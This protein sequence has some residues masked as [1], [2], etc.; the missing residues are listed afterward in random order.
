[1]DA[2]EA[3]RRLAEA[4]GIEARYWDIHGQLHEAAPDT[5]RAL[6]RALGFAADTEA[7]VEAGLAW[8]AEEPWRSPLPSVII[9]RENSEIDVPFRLPADD[10]AKTIRWTVRLETGGIRTGE[11]ELGA[12]Q[13]EGMGRRGETSALLRRFKLAPLPLGYHDLHLAAASEATARLIVAPSRCYLPP[14]FSSLKCWGLAAQLYALK[15]PDDWGIGDFGHLQTLIDRLAAGDADTVG[16]NPLHALF[17]DVPEYVSPYAP[18]SRLFRNSLY[19]DVTAIPDFAE[20]DEARALVESSD[21]ALLLRR[22]RDA[23]F[24]DYKTVAAVK[25]AVLDCLYSSFTANHVARMDGRGAAFRAFTERSGRN[26]DR[27]ATFQMLSEHF[28][29]HDWVRWPAAFRDPQSGLVSELRGSQAARVLFFKYLQWQC[30]EQMAATAELAH[31]RGMAIG[32]YNDLAVSVDAASADH[33]AQQDLFIGGARVG[34]PPDPFN[35]AGQEWGV[36]PLNP[37]RL[38]AAGY[39]PFIALL[40]ANMR[41]TGALR[42]DHVMGWQRLFLIPNGAKPATGAY[43]GYPLDDLLAIAALE[44]HRHRCAVIGEDLGTVQTGFRERM[45]AANV[46]SCRIFAFEREHDRFRRP[47]EYPP[48]ASVSAATH[49][50]ATLSGFWSGADI[51]AKAKLGLFK[52]PAEA[53]QARSGRAVDKRLLLQALADEALLPEGVLP[54][55]LDSLDWSPELVLAVHAY[56]ARSPSLLFLAQLDDLAGE[57]RQAN[58]PGSTTQYPNWRRRQA[59]TID[60]LFDD[61]ATKKQM[62]TIAVERAK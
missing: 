10:G 26:L 44:S 8:F 30:E 55:D 21:V 18:N 48:L 24:V 58:L 16:L 5:V 50:L 56:L 4:A 61:A 25:L 22:A 33:W 54:A 34:A 14:K 60:D 46:L 7:D 36:V 13:I 47:N 42:I 29:T 27:F 35:E 62:T 51:A 15:S 43:V 45:A 59:R 3:L 2:Y 1:M 52:S 32:L 6:L 11:C 38:R 53:A 12:L 9:A 28:A 23:E 39:E 37:L 20:S 31:Q 57:A 17:L 40:R 19:L 49:D 41:H